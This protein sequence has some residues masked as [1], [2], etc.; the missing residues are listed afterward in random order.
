MVWL[1][2]FIQIIGIILL[3]IFARKKLVWWEFTLLLG[4][5]ALLILLINYVMVSYNESDTEYLGG[6][7]D[8]VIY[9]EPWDEEVPCSHSY[10]CNCSTDSKGNQSCSTC[11]MHAY[12]VDYHP[13]HWEKVTNTGKEI[14]ISKSTYDELRARFGTADRF[15]EMHRD[16]HSIDGDAYATDWNREPE[17]SESVTFDH[18]YTN[19]IRASHSIFRLETIDDSAKSKWKLY[20]YPAISGSNQQPV[21]LGRA[22]Q[23]KTDRLLKYVNGWHGPQNQF[24]MFILFFT[25]QTDDVAYKQRSYWEGG[26]KNEFVICI[27]IDKNGMY[28]WNKCFSWMDKPELEVRVRDWLDTEGKSHK[29]IDLDKFAKWMPKQV[30]SYWHRKHFADFNYIQVEVSETQLT[31]LLIIILLYN[32][33]ISI[34]IYKNEFNDGT[35][36][37]RDRVNSIVR[38][39]SEKYRKNHPPKR[40]KFQER[41]EEMARQRKQKW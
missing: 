14:G 2:I 20:D 40:S 34:W 7:V 4:P 18:S 10:Q 1:G 32:I 11:Y 3:L 17:R 31:W 27:G 12:D 21:V 16:F 19:K 9:Y 13:A 39:E 26:N 24:R 5:S 23:T 25:D 36:E 28:K 38:E 35:N 33:G 29:Y 8:H 22:V 37:M 41:L 15:V 6:Y 30:E